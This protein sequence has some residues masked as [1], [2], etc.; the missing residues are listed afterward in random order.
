MAPVAVAVVVV[1]AALLFLHFTGSNGGPS[2]GDSFRAAEA[3]ANGTARSYDS[4]AY[5]QLMLAQAVH[6]RSS[7]NVPITGAGIAGVCSLR[8]LSGG[9]V[10][11]SATSGSAG[12]GSASF[13]E[14]LYRANAS[15]LLTV[16]V[17]QGHATAAFTLNGTGCGQV[18]SGWQPV[19]PGAIDS[20]TAAADANVA[21]G[22]SFL[23]RYPDAAGVYVLSNAVAPGSGA[24]WSIGYTTCP[25]SPEPVGNGSFFVAQVNADTGAVLLLTTESLVCQP[26][27]P[28]GTA[29]LAPPVPVGADFTLGSASQTSNG[30]SSGFCG[31]AGASSDWCDDLPIQSAGGGVTASN[32]EFVVRDPQGNPV[33]FS[34][35]SPTLRIESLAGTSLATYSFAMMSW[36]SG[37]ATGLS[38]TQTLVL[39]LGCTVSGPNLCSPMPTGDLLVALGVGQFTG[40]VQAA[41]A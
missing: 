41:L 9:S 36:T 39:D 12:N 7:L 3:A 32:L 27:Y 8:L 30:S 15:A 23:A 16:V 34:V 22:S 25:E 13:W 20:S 19:P 1:L 21:G 37:G 4:G 29:P 26:F 11:V 31:S 35:G 40:E 14:F 6:G 38:T 2:A 17:D 24:V 28:F 5:S 33:H 10:A 18:Y